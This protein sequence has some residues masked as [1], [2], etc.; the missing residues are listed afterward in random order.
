MAAGAA[1]ADDIPYLG[2]QSDAKQSYEEIWSEDTFAAGM[3]ASSVVAGAGSDL[4]LLAT[5]ILN[6]PGIT[7]ATVHSSGV[8]DQANARQNI[9]DMAAGGPAHRSSYG[10]APG[11]VVMLDGRLL[12]G[13]A[14]PGRAI[15]I[16][17]RRNLRRFAQFQL[18]ALRRRR[19]RF[20]CRQRPR[21]QRHASG[22]G[23][24]QG[25]LPR[26]RCDRGTW[27]WKS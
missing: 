5:T 26:T 21:D 15:Y 25:A 23:R 6:H 22:S 7:L 14:R 12:R 8:V 2:V 20:Q 19:C 27:P 18:A 4:A 1:S 17:R 24:L 13:I 16:L 11:G 10:T 9:A 3:A